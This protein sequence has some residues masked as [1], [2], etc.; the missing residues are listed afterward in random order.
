MSKPDEY[1]VRVELIRLY[2]HFGGRVFFK[3]LVSVLKT[4][5]YIR[6]HEKLVV[7]SMRS[8]DERDL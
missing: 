2:R 7:V 8:L 1:V 6:A 3:A 4:L 5:G